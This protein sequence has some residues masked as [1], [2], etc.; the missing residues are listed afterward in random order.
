MLYVAAEN[1]PDDL[2][3]R[4]TPSLALSERS[5]QA[6]TATVRAKMIVIPWLSVSIACPQ[7]PSTDLLK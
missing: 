7:E 3:Q 1:S 4:P 2:N 5:P 6:E